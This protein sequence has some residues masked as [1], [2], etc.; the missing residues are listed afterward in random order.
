MDSLTLSKE[1]KRFLKENKKMIGIVTTVITMIMILV[2]IFSSQIQSGLNNTDVNNSEPESSAVFQ[3]YVQNVDGNAFQN[4]AAIEAFFLQADR[5]ASIEEQTGV[6]IQTV[7]DE[8]EANGFIKTQADRGVI[9]IA[10]DGSSQVFTANVTVGTAEENLIVLQEFYDYLLSGEIGVLNNKEVFIL[11]TPI[12]LE[13]TLNNVDSE[14]VTEKSGINLKALIMS[15]MIGL[16][17]GGIAGIFISLI[18]QLVK[19]VIT[20]AFSFGW[21]EEDI[22]Q[23][24]N[25]NELPKDMFQQAVLHPYKNVK[26]IVSQGEEHT[27]I[28]NG[29]RE[30]TNVNIINA[31][32]E[33]NKN[34]MNIIIL[35]DLSDINP[36]IK[37]DECI[38]L[39][40]SYRTDKKW[41]TRQ[42]E[43][44]RNYNSQV[45]VIQLVP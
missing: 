3:F 13:D 35:K 42:R 7:L 11:Q 1:L 27:D 15:I 2:S 6:D 28:S 32:D 43:I 36:L 37:I 22:F 30:Y 24:Y 18:A 25:E 29:L 44:L 23:I 17:G 9:G 21:H 34:G 40:A 39:V 10:R 20:Y 14:I 33:L 5:I 26:V 4:S 19:P 31:T 41:Y 12:L 16:F 45:K 38:I 8:Q